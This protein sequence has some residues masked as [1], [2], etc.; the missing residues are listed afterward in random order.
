[1]SPIVV[2][3]ASAAGTSAVE[4]LVA[5]GHEGRVVLLGAEPHPPYS[6]PALSKQFLAGDARA[7]SLPDLP[8]GVEFRPGTTATAVDLRR[9]TVTFRDTTGATASLR[10]AG[11]VVATGCRPRRILPP[12]FGALTVRTIE[13]ATALASALRPDIQVV[14]VGAGFLGLE[15]ATA[16]VRHGAAV[17]VIDREPPLRRLLGQEI[18]ALVS[19]RLAEAGATFV[20]E[21]GGIAEDQD[22]ARG[23]R[24]RSGRRLPADLLIEAVGD[25]PAAEWLRG[26]GI[27]L[28]TNGSV[29]SDRSG[30]VG[31]HV[32][33]AG[34]VRMSTSRTPYWSAAIADG[35]RAARTLL[36]MPAPAPAPGYFWTEVFGLSVRVLGALPVRGGL[37]VIDGDLD[38]AAAVVAWTGAT[39]AINHPIPLRRLRRA[40]D[41]RAE[42]TSHV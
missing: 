21:P 15:L 38:S 31:E 11:L 25:E 14:V 35:R 30:R 28:H 22:A 27:P 12:A 36:G 33:A 1:M 4:E 18:S 17:T 6:R 3:G 24:L 7:V 37:R 13:D 23:F 5:L 16:A 40:L 2:V 39:A 29:L 42:E 41:D 20:L 9:R 34:D 8:A 19:R 26:S 10:Y 32:V